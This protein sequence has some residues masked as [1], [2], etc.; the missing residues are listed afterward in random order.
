[1]PFYTKNVI[2]LPRQ[3]RD[4][5]RERALK[6]RKSVAGFF[7]VRRY[8]KITVNG[9]GRI[10]GQKMM[11]AFSFQGQSDMWSDPKLGTYAHTSFIYI[12]IRAFLNTKR[13]DRFFVC[14]DDAIMIVFDGKQFLSVFIRNFGLV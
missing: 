1:M 7:F 3:A 5:H 12:Y 13:L 8:G 11:K 2:I 14:D 10:N 4:K 9:F 6:N